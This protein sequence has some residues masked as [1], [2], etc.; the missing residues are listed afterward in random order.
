[1]SL[2]KP[3]VLERELRTNASSPGYINNL[4]S[5]FYNTH[6]IPKG[7][8]K[9]KFY[10]STVNEAGENEVYTIRGRSF[11]GITLLINPNTISNNMAKIVNRSQTMTSW[12]EEHWGEE[13]DTITFQGSSA[14]FIWMGPREEIPRGPLDMTPREIQQMYNDYMKIPDLGINE[15]L[16]IGDHSGLTV[17]QRRNT[18]AYDQFRRIIHLMNA[19]AANFNTQG[20]VR[21]RKFIQ[22]A[23]DV[24]SY[25]GYFESID[26]TE[27]AESP[28]KFIYTAT[29][30]CEKTI[31]NYLR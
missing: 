4:D 20:F 8:S 5:Y 25:R 26:I 23:Y 14:G 3:I 2:R 16:G 28:F 21:K 27:D 12:L 7:P 30:K 19:N 22:L 18:M 24:A 15:P 1:M 6:D 10:I 29:F 31:F 9:V 11:L 13:L 17:K